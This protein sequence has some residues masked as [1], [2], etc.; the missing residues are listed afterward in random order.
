MPDIAFLGAYNSIY[1]LMESDRITWIS[2]RAHRKAPVPFREAELEDLAPVKRAR[3][4]LVVESDLPPTPPIDGRPAGRDDRI[5]QTIEDVEVILTGQ[6]ITREHAGFGRNLTYWIVAPREGVSSVLLSVELPQ[7][8]RYR[9]QV[10]ALSRQGR[11]V[12]LAEDVS[13]TIITRLRW[14]VEADTIVVETDSTAGNVTFLVE[15]LVDA[16]LSDIAVL[17]AAGHERAGVLARAA[18]GVGFV[19]CF[20]VDPHAEGE[21][22]MVNAA[23]TRIPCRRLLTIGIPWHNDLES[24]VDLVSIDVPI[25]SSVEVGQ[26]LGITAAPATV[27][28]PDQP[29][30]YGPALLIALRSG[31]NLR[32]D[33]GDADYIREEEP[34]GQTAR[35]WRL[36]DLIGVPLSTAPE[37]DPLAANPSTADELVICEST[38]EDLL[39]CQA[40]GYA[41]LNA[42]KLAFLRPIPPSQTAADP[43]PGS[44][45]ASLEQAAADAVPSTLLTPHVRTMTVFT[46]WLPLHLTPIPSEGEWAPKQHWVDRYVLAHLPGNTASLLVP[47]IF[48]ASTKPSQAVPFAVVFDTLG[49]VTDTE[50]RQFVDELSK[51]LGYPLVLAQESADGELLREVAERLETDLLLLVTHGAGD[52]IEDGHGGRLTSS[53]IASWKVNGSPLVFNNSCSSWS[54]TGAAFVAAGARGYIGALWP[55][56]SRTATQIGISIAAGLHASSGADIPMLLTAAVRAAA[57]E[58]GEAQR[59]AAAYLYVGVPGTQ[60]LTR[61]P[62]GEREVVALMTEVFQQFYDLLAQLVDAGRPDL[63]ARLHASREPLRRR[64]SAIAVP[65]EMPPSMSEPFETYTSLEAELLLSVADFNLGMQML[66]SIPHD[67]QPG[68][69]QQM[70]QFLRRAVDELV[71]W[72]ERHR[73][74]M[75]RLPAE[76]TRA[77]APAG[78]PVNTLGLSAS[79][80]VAAR[81]VRKTMLPF[82]FVLADQHEDAKA[83]DWLDL[84]MRMVLDPRA[85]QPPEAARDADV[86]ST[87]RGGILEEASIVW[88]PNDA[89]ELN[90]PELVAGRTITIDHLAHA[91]DKADLAN[92]FGVALL[93][94]N[95]LGRAARFFETARDL[96]DPASTNRANA[97]SNLGNAFRLEGRL[98]EAF[99]NYTEALGQQRRLGDLRNASVTTANLL[100]VAPQM[101]AAV[102]LQVVLDI[103]QWIDAGAEGLAHLELSCDVLGALACYYASRDQHQE[104][105]QTADKILEYVRAGEFPAVACVHANELAEWY[106]RFGEHHLAAQHFVA[107]ASLFK[108]TGLSELA[109]RSWLLATRANL[110]AYQK[111]GGRRYLQ[112]FFECSEEIAQARDRVT[113]PEF[114]S[115]YDTVRTNTESEWQQMSARGDYAMAAAAYRAVTAWTPGK[116][117]AEWNLLSYAFHPRNR[118]AIERA[119][120]HGLLVRQGEVVID[121]RIAVITTIRTVWLTSDGPSAADARQPGQLYGYLPIVEYAGATFEKQSQG[122]LVAG[123]AVYVLRPG[124]SVAVVGQ[125]PRRIRTN[126]QGSYVYEAVWGSPLIRYERLTLALA[127]GLVPIVVQCLPHFGPQ[128]DA[129][130]QFRPDGCRLYLEPADDEHAAWLARVQVA[131]T[132]EAEVAS[133]VCARADAWATPIPYAHYARMLQSLLDVSAG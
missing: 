43:A 97:I 72:D 27:I 128:L 74:H 23:L 9:V 99:A 133:A 127:N 114:T 78:L 71:T 5:P 111:T 44:A 121:Q 34:S 122:A 119:A 47:R 104:A 100:R 55:I 45:Y 8:A 64:L 124:E 29:E 28:A 84:A 52:F 115:H 22:E 39:I 7:F 75:E 12:Q 6:A 16:R 113:A 105:A 120:V 94:L 33:T 61:S 118:E 24:D 130:I 58:R 98:Q 80:S 81:M 83:R 36:A 4:E 123:A 67:E 117:T 95:E 85:P 69:I 66:P 1:F 48:Q 91:A 11:T 38:A 3:S 87:L 112:S 46:R 77:G 108:R 2:D 32:F 31:A 37:V 19:P 18:C 57:T 10:D 59:T 89:A 42:Y 15:S 63:A 70:D 14:S 62:F 116:Q 126:G 13:F 25:A 107:N 60:L 68:L 86:V 53:D 49:V 93:K 21:V 90:S 88:S 131:F 79:V 40:V 132:T 20:V 102:D 109:T 92:A 76:G 54:T 129:T 103:L 51:G 56:A 41:S 73:R 110:R 82:V 26:R 50:Q 17:V 30:A 35:T 106:Y 65:G 101:G 125:S 96:A